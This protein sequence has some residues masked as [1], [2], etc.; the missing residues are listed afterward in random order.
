MLA[1]PFRA[2]MSPSY[3]LDPIVVTASR[4]SEPSLRAAKSVTV[5]DEEEI[6]RYMP[7]SVPELLKKEAGILVR[8]Y[9]GNGKTAQVDIRGFGEP[10]LS[11]VLV[12]V[13][14]RRTTQIDMSGTDWTQIDVDSIERI[15]IVRGPQTVLYGDNATGGV[16]NII[17]KS[18]AG[19]KPEA[20]FT[21][22]LGSY[23]YDA[24]KTFIQ[25]GTDFLDYYCSASQSSTDGYRVNNHLETIDLN[26]T[27][28]VKPAP[29]ARLALYGGYHKDWY[30]MPG[31]LTTANLNAFGR[32]GSVYPND[33]SKTDDFYLMAG[34]ELTADTD[35]GEVRVSSDFLGRG[36]RVSSVFYSTWGTTEVTSHIKTFGITPKVA[37][38]A[39][40]FGM[41]NRL[42]TGV[43]YYAD[44]DEIL[45]GDPG[46]GKDMIVITKDS[47]GVYAADSLDVTQALGAHAGYRA[48]WAMYRF[49]QQAVMRGKNRKTPFEQ[50]YEAGLNFRYNEKSSVYANYSRSFRF[51]A[52][53][54]WYSALWSFW[55]LAGGGLNLDLKP[56]TGN[57]FE[58][59]IRENSSKYL[60]VKASY[61]L[62]DLRHELYFNPVTLA[63]SIY[64]RT[65]R[66]GLEL[67]T[68]A[69]LF[70]G[71]DASVNYT[72]EKAFFVGSSFAGNEV[73]MVPRHKITGSIDYTFMDCVNIIYS[74]SY[75][76]PMRFTSDQRNVVPRLK[77]YMTHDVKLS[78]NKYGLSIYGAIYNIFNE[79]YD[80]Y[81]VTNALGTVQSHYPAPGTNFI[82]GVTYTF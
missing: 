21:Y 22:R 79:K 52:V 72:Y 74:A 10:S 75:V 9:V 44:K 81:G 25:G 82:A 43:D 71:F 68:H 30:G 28:T 16:V 48:E 59:G 39:D 26:G 1:S 51:P 13:D 2:F 66:H 65:I 17:T 80:A 49:D 18:G 12:L 35:L 60:G 40:V 64:D 11:N 23:N 31:A 57:N 24:Y 8:D 63:N 67:E 76:S 47:V 62:M 42:I 61:F 55:G 50:A 37:F 29:Y 4:Y 38:T 14:G 20:G 19:K 54:E 45:S 34:P 15:E 5:I 73:P 69:Y 41:H 33:R 3:R 36:R 77:S 6:A 56:Q 58:V 46:I 70:H 53:D 78:Y 32:R 27:I 7:R